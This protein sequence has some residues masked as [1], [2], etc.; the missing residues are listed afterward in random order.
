[1]RVF[2][3]SSEKVW[4]C[5]RLA[6]EAHAQARQENDPVRKERFFEIERRYI[7]VA[8]SHELTESFTDF[9]REIRRFN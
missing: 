6:A 7:R 4:L 5:Y 8:Q 1:L 3:R 9:G 2:K